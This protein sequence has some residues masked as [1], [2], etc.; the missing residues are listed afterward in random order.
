AGMAVQVTVLPS[1]KCLYDD[2]VQICVAGLQ[3]EQAVTLR[4]SVV[5]EIGELFEAHA[6]YRADSSGELDL[7]R[8]PALAGSYS[9]VEPMG[10]LWSLKSKT[11]YKRL[12]KR[13]VL[14]PFCVDIEVYEGHGD[15]NCLLGKCT[16]E[17]WFLKEGVM[18][19]PVREGRLKATLFLPPGPGPFPGLIDLY[20]SGR[21]LMEYRASLLASRGFVTLALAYVAFEGLPAVPEALEL[22][23]FE[24]GLNFMQKQPQ[25]KD[26]GIGVLGLSKGADLGLA[27]A[28]FLPGIKA[29]VSISGSGIN[30][31]VPLR[32]D[33]FTIREHPYDLKRM[34]K[35]D[36]TGLAEFSELLDDHTDPSTWDCRLP[37]ERSLAK[38]LF[39]SGLD[40][41]TLKS[42]LYCRDA[43]QRLQQHG[44]EVEF[45]SYPGTGHLLEPPFLPLCQASM[46]KTLE[47]YARWGGQWKE[48]AKAQEDAWPRIQDF[49][50]R[51]L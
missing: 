17:R 38:F 44:R 25:V 20:G 28:A 5:D 42:D 30:Y 47:V 46:Y 45:Y 41:T 51:H 29:A 1:P 26:T 40:D 19:I 21:G 10:L 39:L 11:P 50:R 4:A 9:G 37:L 43:V 7:S 14:S 31:F 16:N 18:R 33:G 13:D 6:H 15:M 3:P 36:E 24:E 22:S 12:A 8:S 32:G 23:Y 27:M 34:K 48:H 2:P 35:N 49:F